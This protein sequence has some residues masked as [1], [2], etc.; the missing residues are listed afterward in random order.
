MSKRRQDIKK[1]LVAFTQLLSEKGAEGGHVFEFLSSY[2]HNGPA[3]HLLEMQLAAW[4]EAVA[5]SE[6]KKRKPVQIPFD[7][8]GNLLTDARNKWRGSERKTPDGVVW[9]ENY[10]FD[11]R[12]TY[13]SGASNTIL[14]VDDFGRQYPMFL[15]RLGTALEKV[16]MQGNTMT[17][18]WTFVRGGQ[19][20]SICV[21]K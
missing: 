5:L 19:N 3:R 12:L 10:E 1:D 20:F 4:K 2:T 15:S 11:A 6:T 8:S 18:R 13:L 9:K 21:V 16:G 17:G 7:S 14:W